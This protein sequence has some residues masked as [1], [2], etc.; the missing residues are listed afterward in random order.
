MRRTALLLAA[1]AAA[2]SVPVLAAPPKAPSAAAEAKVLD[3]SKQAIALRSVQGE[4]NK[5]AEVAQL[6]KRAL[7]G[8]GWA[9]MPSS[10]RW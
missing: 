10:S 6:Y 7:L 2:V 9:A 1:T 4:G 8:A 3:L 5:T